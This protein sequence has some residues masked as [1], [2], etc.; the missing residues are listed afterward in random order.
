[1]RISDTGAAFAA[2]RHI[3]AF[4]GVLGTGM[5]ITSEKRIPQDTQDSLRR[6]ISGYEAAL[7]RFLPRSLVRAMGDPQG[8]AEHNSIFEFPEYCRPLFDIY[9]SLYEATDGR[10]DPCI[11]ES[12]IRLG[13]S[14]PFDLIGNGPASSGPVGTAPGRPRSISAG[15]TP[16][17]FHTADW[18]SIHR[19]GA[20]LYTRT[21]VSLDFGAAGKGFCVDLLSAQLEALG[22]GAFTIDAG[23]DLYFSTARSQYSQD[24]QHSHEAG[25]VRDPHRPHKSH[26][27][28]AGTRITRVALEDPSDSDT[29]IGICTIGRSPYEPGMRGAALCASAPGRRTWTVRRPDSSLIQAHHIL[30]ALTGEPARGVEAA[31]VYVPYA[32]SGMEYPTAWA[33]GLATALF[34]CGPQHL[35]NSTPPEIS[36]EFLRLLGG[37]PEKRTTT[38]GHSA[39]NA[40]EDA[41]GHP[42]AHETRYTAQHSPGFPA[43]IFIE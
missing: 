41:A 34:V 12:L 40:S 26:T 16:A 13:Y 22:C 6:S 9:D 33:D 4:P 25:D 43:E 31:W 28:Q 21:P 8:I 19:E 1:M 14:V 23:G 29:A 17:G 18:R 38:A 35:Y 24:S 2:E 5:I 10:I 3:C 32:S 30:D 27:V 36:F 7:S 37:Y 20:T 15:A 39:E 42:A 11:G